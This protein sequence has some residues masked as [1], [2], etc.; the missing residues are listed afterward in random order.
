MSKVRDLIEMTGEEK[1]KKERLGGG[2][3]RDIIYPMGIE[4]LCL[5]NPKS[6]TRGPRVVGDG[7][8]ASPDFKSQ[9]PYATPFAPS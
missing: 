7:C 8:A 2:G 5:A 1:R 3:Q 4:F 9:K 6:V